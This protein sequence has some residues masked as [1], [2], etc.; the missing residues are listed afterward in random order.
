MGIQ[1][2]GP[3]TDVS[4]DLAPLP[5]PALDELSPDLLAWLPLARFVLRESPRWSQHF[6]GKQDLARFR[7]DHAFG[8]SD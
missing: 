4:L 5:E 7:Q 3:G 6:S 2:H 8:P 1:G